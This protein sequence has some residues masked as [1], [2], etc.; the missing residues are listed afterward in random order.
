MVTFDLWCALLGIA[1]T[2]DAIVFVVCIIWNVGDLWPLVCIIVNWHLPWHYSFG[3]VHYLEFLWPL[4]FS[5][6]NTFVVCIIWNC[7][8]LWPSP[9][10]SGWNYWCKHLVLYML[11]L[12]HA[13][14]FD[15]WSAKVYL[16][17]PH[18]CLMMGSTWP[19][20]SEVKLGCASATLLV[21]ALVHMTITHLWPLTSWM[22][23]CT[24]TA[25]IDAYC[26]HWWVWHWTFD[27]FCQQGLTVSYM[28]L[29]FML[30]LF[31]TFDELTAG[32]R[33]V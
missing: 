27:L 11:Q 25:H 24:L 2:F 33:L 15:E 28:L 23:K 13:V 32:Y 17:V 14:T 4:T 18:S 12:L 6:A 22:P 19:L 31:V 21:P 1:V 5:E 10:W 8:D 3:G 29:P 26:Y 16:D 30:K 20:T 9:A 7:G